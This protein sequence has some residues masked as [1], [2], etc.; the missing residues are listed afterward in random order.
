MKKRD[1]LYAR[2]KMRATQLGTVCHTELDPEL[3]KPIV[4]N[5]LGTIVKNLIWTGY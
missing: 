2:L 1:D 4:K 5:N 3:D